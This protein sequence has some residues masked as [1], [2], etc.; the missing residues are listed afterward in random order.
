MSFHLLQGQ[1][2]DVL[3]TPLLFLGVFAIFYFIVIRPQGRERKKLEAARENLKKGDRVLTIGG[4][5][6][7]VQQV[8]EKEIVLDLDGSS[9]MTITKAAIQTIFTDEAE[10]AA[11]AKSAKGK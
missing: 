6:A 1:G 8:K 2:S 3:S 4:V 5:L 7:S 10:A 9:R 11:A